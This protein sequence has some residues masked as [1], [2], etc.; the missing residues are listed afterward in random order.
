MTWVACVTLVC[1]TVLALYA[2]KLQDRAKARAN[3]RLIEAAVARVEAAAAEHAA[4]QA[5]TTAAAVAEVKRAEA[6]IV[7]H[8]Q[9]L[10]ALWNRQGQAGRFT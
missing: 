1:L 2:M 9:K 10:V 8:E 3:E 6:S 7:E 4:K 5:A